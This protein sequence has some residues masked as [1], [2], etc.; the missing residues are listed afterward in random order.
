[1]EVNIILKNPKIKELIIAIVFLLKNKISKIIVKTTLLIIP[2]LIIV[3]NLDKIK[4][5]KLTTLYSLE[6][7]L[8]STEITLDSTET[9][10]GSAVTIDNLKV[11][12][13]SGRTNGSRHN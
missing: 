7:T 9:I 12:Q 13:K 10:L 1:M 6:I 8:D 5:L 3:M 4:I 11:I 2:I